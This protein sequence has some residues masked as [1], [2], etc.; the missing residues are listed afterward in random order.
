MT[1]VIAHID[2]HERFRF[3]C[4]LLQALPGVHWHFLTGRLSLYH[5]AKA[6]GL[7]CHWLRGAAPVAPVPRSDSLE[8]RLNWRTPTQLA[9]L[10]N[11]VWHTL[12]QLDNPDC[13]Y[14]LWNG[15]RA[16][17][18]TMADFARHE[19][20][21]TLFLE[22]GN[23]PQRLFAD[24][25]G[26][27]ALSRL[28]RQPTI[29]EE[30]PDDIDS[31][32]TWRRDY[33]AQSNIPAQSGQVRRINTQG[34]QDQIG[35]FI[36]GHS[37]DQAYGKGPSANCRPAGTSYKQKSAPPRSPTCCTQCRSVRTASWCLTVILIIARPSK[38]PRP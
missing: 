6:Q 28:A 4:R 26:V 13:I 20:R 24:P 25:E 7:R 9:A 16:V 11:R 2:C 14:L 15:C 12:A 29:L 30:L 21:S 8:A 38:R 32:N 36:G 34:W 27:N 17:E 33:F 31:F 1:Q 18:K 22:L 37:S 35:Y 10:H 5:A 23:F 19:Q 3:Y